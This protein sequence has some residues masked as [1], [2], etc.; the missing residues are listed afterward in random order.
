MLGGCLQGPEMV[1]HDVPDDLRVDAEI[2]ADHDAAQAGH[3]PPGNLRMPLPQLFGKVL[4]RFPDDLEVAQNGVER[5]LVLDE[6]SKVSVSVQR[7]ILT[8]AS[9]ISSS[10]SLGSRDTELLTLDPLLE[11]RLEG[12]M[13]DEIHASAQRSLEQTPELHEAV[14]TGRPLELHENIDVAFGTTLAAGEGTEQCERTDAEPEKL[15]GE[16]SQSAQRLF[17][18]THRLDH[19]PLPLLFNYGASLNA[20]PSLASPR[21]VRPQRRRRTDVVTNSR[22]KP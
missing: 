7:R 13:C 9:R 17:A 21:P 14:E 18:C 16:L 20:T 11:A 3:V 5:P 4:D 15:G 12:P 1:A 19:G 8:Q 22:S 2:A 10:L 6:P